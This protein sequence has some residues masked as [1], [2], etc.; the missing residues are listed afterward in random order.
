VTITDE[1]VERMAR[2][3]FAQSTEARSGFTWPI[4]GDWGRQRD[5][6]RART[7]LE[8]VLPGPKQERTD[9]RT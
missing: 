3:I 5:L 8:Y 4:N 1:M 2:M 6:E 9:T 7:I